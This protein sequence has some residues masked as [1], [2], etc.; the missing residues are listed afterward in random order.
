VNNNIHNFMCRK[1]LLKLK[2]I[3]KKSKKYT[4]EDEVILFKIIM[5]CLN[6][7]IKDLKTK[8]LEND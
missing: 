2:V 7:I 1:C 3:S 8:Q 4:K 6:N 5:E